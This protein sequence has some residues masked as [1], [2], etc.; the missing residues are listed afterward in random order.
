MK[1]SAIGIMLLS[2][3]NQDAGIISSAVSPI[4]PPHDYIRR[5]CILFVIRRD[6]LF[7]DFSFHG[8]RIEKDY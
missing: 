7:F 1:I 4:R 6:I 2:I 5:H 3:S 8:Y